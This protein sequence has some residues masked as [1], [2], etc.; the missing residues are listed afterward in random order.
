M[1]QTNLRRY[2]PTDTLQ[3]KSDRNNKETP[4]G[5]GTTES[6]ALE[7]NSKC[8]DADEA[9]VLRYVRDNGAMTREELCYQSRLPEN[10][11]DEILD[12]L[13]QQELI[14]VTSGDTV[15]QIRPGSA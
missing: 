15:V 6:G 14:D 9:A 7:N 3:P 1:I 4:S 11:V 13:K 2:E 5:G 8:L 10:H 12:S